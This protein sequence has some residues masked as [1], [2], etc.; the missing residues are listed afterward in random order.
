[1]VGV[2][3]ED[4]AGDL[5]VA[6]PVDGV[7]AGEVLAVGCLW[8]SPAEWMRILQT[9]LLAIRLTKDFRSTI[10]MASIVPYDWE[11]ES[12]HIE[13]RTTDLT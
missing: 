13:E 2:C 8:G 7:V 5:A 10:L 1:V 12:S 6:E 9:F 3:T 4:V 11:M